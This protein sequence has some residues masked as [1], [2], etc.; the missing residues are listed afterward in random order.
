MFCSGHRWHLR[1]IAD[2]LTIFIVILID[3]LFGC[4]HYFLDI[5]LG[6]A[7]LGIGNQLLNK[8]GRA[9]ET[10]E[11]HVATSE[12]EKPFGIGM[13]EYFFDPFSEVCEKVSNLAATTDFGMLAAWYPSKHYTA[14]KIRLQRFKGGWRLG[15]CWVA[16]H[17]GVD[18]W[19][20]RLI[21]T[22][23]PL[24]HFTTML[25]GKAYE[26]SA[27]PGFHRFQRVRGEPAIIVVNSLIGGY[28]LLFH[29]L[30]NSPSH[31][32]KLVQHVDRID[33][34]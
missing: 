30:G 21:V 11:A 10:H 31:I 12:I 14:L 1:T 28:P 29:I 2:L 16:C 19:R 32:G 15:Y 17:C 18:H 6:W 27:L 22:T 34:L 20:I 25:L 33:Y 9:H 3:R 26:A 7:V 24:K 13:R 5:R 4:T 8:A 23:E